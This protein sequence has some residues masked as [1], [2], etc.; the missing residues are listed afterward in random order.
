MI[1]SDLTLLVFYLFYLCFT[2]IEEFEI[3]CHVL[4]KYIIKTGVFPTLV[5]SYK[6][7]FL[8]D[9]NRTFFL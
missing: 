3:K 2:K 9:F 5:F 4:K 1:D 6:I 7:L 8:R